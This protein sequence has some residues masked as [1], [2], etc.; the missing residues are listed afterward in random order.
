METLMAG[1]SSDDLLAMFDGAPLNRRYWTIFAI[2]SAVFVLDFFDFFL[3]AFVMSV[4]GREWHLTY[5]QGAV[6]LYAAGLGAIIGSLVWGALGDRF[7]RKMQT[8][9][10]TFICG[11]SAGLIAFVPTGDWVLLAI[12]RFFVGFG[13]AAGVTPH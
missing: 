12:L 1:Q 9:S 10:G 5:G 8:V 11:I 2:M 7:G 3:I 13:L 6:I 4:I